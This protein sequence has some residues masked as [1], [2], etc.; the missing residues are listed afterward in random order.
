MSEVQ[1]QIEPSA[2]QWALLRNPS[3]R[4]LVQANAGAAKTTT[5][6]LR[7]AAALARQPRPEWILALTYSEPAVQ[8]LR[9]RLVSVGVSPRLARQVPILSFE[10]YSRLVLAR[11]EGGPVADRPWAEDLQG[12]MQATLSAL[13]LQR[14]SGAPALEWLDQCSALDTES[15]LTAFAPIKGRMLLAHEA[16][17]QRVTP[18]LADE[19]GVDYPVLKLFEAFESWRWPWSEDMPRFRAPQDAVY[20]LAGK[21]LASSPPEVMARQLRLVLVDEMH[22]THRAMFTVLKGVLQA[23]PDALFLGVGDRDQVIHARDGAD[24]AFMGEVFDREVGE[25]VHAPLSASYRFGGTL[26]GLMGQV[27]LKPYLSALTTDTG[28]LRCGWDDEAGWLKL[29]EGLCASAHAAG[30]LGD[31]AILVRDPDETV[32]LEHRLLDRGLPCVTPGLTPFLRRRELL[33]VRALY[34]YASGRRHSIR[35]EDWPQALD[36]LMRLAQSEVD[37][38]ELAKLG[39][40]ERRRQAIAAAVEEAR[41][42]ESHPS[43]RLRSCWHALASTEGQPTAA[44]VRDATIECDPILRFIRLQV[45]RCAAPSRKQRLRA[46]CETLQQHDP[47]FMTHFLAHLQAHE[48]VKDTLVLHDDREAFVRT[49][50]A[51]R[52]PAADAGDPM[53]FF[54]RLTAMDTQHGQPGRAGAPRP[55]AV[56]LTTIEQAKGLEWPDVILP[57]ADQSRFPDLAHQVASQHLLYVGMTRASRRLLLLGDRRKPLALPLDEQPFHLAHW[58]RGLAPLDE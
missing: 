2:E 19:L 51:L 44:H 12:D 18:E 25:A 40:V 11:L 31:L 22:D 8:A 45:W 32:A 39:P 34:A 16:P 20:D 29:V 55:G 38:E 50:H 57:H 46:A 43:L 41:L 3:R 27:A 47:G 17:D 9:Q 24:A 30:E 54:D 33:F 1:L 53:R 58:Q 10:Q 23:N 52:A 6:A 37:S 48:L 21:L 14:Q 36:I 35:L 56:T 4:I 15:L 7:I 13:H 26:A 5:L 28:V 49:L 42:A